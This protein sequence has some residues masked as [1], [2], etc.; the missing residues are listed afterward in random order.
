MIG[1]G[2]AGLTTAIRLL[3]AGVP[4]RVLAREMPL[5]TVSAV[6]G[7]LILPVGCGPGQRVRRWYRESL[8][9]WRALAAHS[10][11]GVRQVPGRLFLAA[12]AEPEGFRDL[13]SLLDAEEIPSRE[14]PRAGLR[15]LRLR[16]PVV[17]MALCLPFLV[18]RLLQLGGRLEQGAVHRLE[19][20][21]A[22]HGGVVLCAGLGAAALTGDR[23]LLPVRGQ[24]LRYPL[25]AG[26]G[27]PEFYVDD[28]HPEGLLYALPRTG[29]WRV[30]GTW[31]EGEAE[32][33]TRPEDLLAIE[34]RARSALP[35]LAGLRPLGAEAGIRPWR[36]EVRLEAEPRRGG[37]LV[38]N[39]GHGGAGV[40]L[41]WGCA[42]EAAERVLAALPSAPGIR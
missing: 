42:R 27:E 29:E 39:H 36:A 24:I 13:L 7:A 37:L 10:G 33:R 1:A 12:G 9:V 11:T 30:G 26:G 2:I 31:E 25:P 21:F 32:A 4:V 20:A 3:E 14:H 35:F 40:S 15:G 34:A 19:E 17:D 23:G 16:L 8:A 5:E 41:A 6:A 28:S 38:H 22:S 18:R